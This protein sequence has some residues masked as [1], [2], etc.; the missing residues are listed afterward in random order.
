[1]A[2]TSFGP[3]KFVL[4]TGRPSHWASL[5]APGQNANGDII[6]GMSSIFYKSWYVECSDKKR[7]DSTTLSATIEE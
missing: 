7:I 5:I 1:M 6:L 3:T 4:D 2:R